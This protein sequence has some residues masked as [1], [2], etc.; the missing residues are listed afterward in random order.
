MT[1]FRGLPPSGTCR[2]PGVRAWMS[3]VFDPS[4][5]SLMTHSIGCM[6]CGVLR[7][8]DD[9]RGRRRMKGELAADRIVAIRCHM[10]EEQV[11]WYL[12]IGM[13]S[14][15]EVLAAGYELIEVPA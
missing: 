4:S 6:D 3:S 9:W 12:E 1:D 5:P 11:D 7:H 8:S 2:H 14:E 10:T 13:I 15:A